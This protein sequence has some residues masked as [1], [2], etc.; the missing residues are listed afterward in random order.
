M[1]SSKVKSS[2]LVVP[3]GSDSSTESRSGSFE[4]VPL[5]P[6]TTT[7]NV[8]FPAE[9]G[10]VEN[11]WLLATYARRDS[12]TGLVAAGKPIRT[13][14][15]PLPSGFELFEQLRSTPLLWMLPLLS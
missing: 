2:E 7:E 1:P 12:S 6:T 9:F 3:A 13:L 5:P 8:G 10:G 14:P 15:L 11:T 4:F